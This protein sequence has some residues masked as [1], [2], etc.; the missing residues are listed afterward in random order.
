M[1]ENKGL[2]FT[3]GVSSVLILIGVWLRLLINYSF[4]FVI[5]GSVIASLGRACSTHAPPKVSLKWFLPRNRAIITSVLVM[6]A[7]FGVI[8]GY[9]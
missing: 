2:H 4:Y 9:I 1:I 7:P 5:I 3:I 6:M 8:G